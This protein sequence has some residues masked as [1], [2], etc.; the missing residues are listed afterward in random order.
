MNFSI[1]WYPYH[2]PFTPQKIANI[3]INYIRVLHNEL[4]EKNF[5]GELADWVFLIQ[6]EIER[7]NQ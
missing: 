4:D 2:V 7:L 6:D 1:L 3:F 5:Y